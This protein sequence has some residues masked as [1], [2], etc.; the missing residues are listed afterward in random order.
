MYFIKLAFFLISLSLN[1]LA[2]Q[3]KKVAIIGSGISGANTARLLLQ[4]NKDFK[5]DLYESGSQVGG[6]IQSIPYNN[7]VLEAGSVLFIKEQR[8]IYNLVDE[9]KLEKEIIFTA[10]SSSVVGIFSNNS[11]NIEFGSSNIA[12]V[13]KM[14]WRYGMSPI[15]M[16][17]K[18]DEFEN[19]L[20]PV[21]DMLEKKIPLRDI[22]EIISILD[23]KDLV[24]KTM[25]TYIS[26]MG[27]NELYISEMLNATMRAL[28]SQ[29]DMTVL[30]TFS[31]LS[32]L[33]KELYH[34]KGGTRKLVDALID[35]CEKSKDNFKLL[36][37]TNVISISKKDPAGRYILRSSVGSEEY[38]IIIIA[39]PLS[40]AK[41]EFTD[42]LKHLNKFNNL[43]KP[44]SVHVT[45]IEGQLNNESFGTNIFPQILIPEQALTAASI[46][47]IYNFGGVYKI[48]SLGRLTQA[49]LEKS[50]L[51]RDGFKVL[52]SFGWSYACGRFEP[53]LDFA[54]IPGYILDTRLFYA[55]AIE[56]IDVGMEEAIFSSQNVVNIIQDMYIG[57]T[58]KEDI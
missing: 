15:R 3:T 19:K 51:F 26:E 13:I 47:A 50:K 11:I 8:L 40:V 25:S 16:R 37:N 49:E 1:T 58:L 45:Y 6:R 23:M 24:D 33:G 32:K 9:L 52:Y 31:A 55:N 21:Y 12:N 14:I 35:I 29:Q 2:Q 5:V 22:E 27:L 20:E 53:M 36:L 30:A 46:T 7:T 17:M 34:I 44:V 18:I 39:A 28:Y 54:N 10:D 41:I 4:N 57:K 56:I 42:L 48:H 38:D 43:P